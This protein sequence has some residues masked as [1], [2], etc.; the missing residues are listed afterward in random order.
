M[1]FAAALSPPASDWAEWKANPLFKNTMAERLSRKTL[2][3]P[4]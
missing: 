4:V 1:G 2:Y 3:D